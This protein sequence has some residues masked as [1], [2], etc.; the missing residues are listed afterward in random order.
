MFHDDYLRLGQVYPTTGKGIIETIGD[1]FTLNFADAGGSYIQNMDRSYLNTHSYEKIITPVAERTLVNGKLDISTLAQYIGTQYAEKWNR[2]WDAIM[3]EYSITEN[4]S[5]VEEEETNAQK[6]ETLS[7]SESE[8]IDRDDTVSETLH[9]TGTVTDANSG[10]DTISGTLR[11]T[12]TITDANSGSDNISG[13][14]RKTGTVT[15]GHTGSDTIT[16]SGEDNNSIYG[17][18]SGTA[19]PSDKSTTSGTETTQKGTTDTQTLNTTDTNSET[20]SKSYQDTITNDTTDTTSETVSKSSQ[21]TVTNNTTDTTTGS[22]T[23]D[24]TNSKTNSSTG[25]TIDAITRTL[26]RRGNIGVTT[27]SQMQVEYLK[28]LDEWFNF[29]KMVFDDIDSILTLKIY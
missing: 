1:S 24:Q 3:I 27:N 25:Q 22:S 28:I 14:L 15:D 17:L 10:T 19:S 29:C 23:V 2:Y 5:M 6:D 8:T 18:N 26:T 9:K 11:K 16:R 13:S 12:G 7:G 21:N 4:Y 20:I